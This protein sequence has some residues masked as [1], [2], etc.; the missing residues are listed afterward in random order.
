MGPMV[1]ALGQLWIHNEW[2]I[3][4]C[5]VECI[6]VALKHNHKLFKVV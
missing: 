1:L 5:M 3:L 4:V 6:V 2:G